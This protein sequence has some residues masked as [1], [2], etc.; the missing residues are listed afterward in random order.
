MTDAQFV[1]AISYGISRLRNASGWVQ[2]VDSL[3]RTRAGCASPQTEKPG[4]KSP[5]SEIVVIE[6]KPWVCIAWIF[7]KPLGKRTS[8]LIHA[9]L[10]FV[11]IILILILHPINGSLDPYYGSP[12]STFSGVLRWTALGADSWVLTSHS[13]TIAAINNSDER[14]GCL[15]SAQY[16]REQ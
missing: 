8:R 2:L 15:S 12:G 6:L 9:I 1:L 14:G 16:E 10:N 3:R 7:R 11:G 5:L 4:C 13:W